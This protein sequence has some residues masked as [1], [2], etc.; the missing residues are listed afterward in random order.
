MNC[1]TA[2][3]MCLVAIGAGVVAQVVI[4]SLARCEWWRNRGYELCVRCGKWR[5]KEEMWTYV[6]CLRCH[7][8]KE[9]TDERN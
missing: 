4:A 3:N 7:A 9:E 1:D 5:P 2:L 6:T 8:R